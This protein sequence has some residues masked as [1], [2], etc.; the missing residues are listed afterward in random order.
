M[1]CA[2]DKR[3]RTQ[4]LVETVLFA[5]VRLVCSFLCSPS[6]SEFPFFMVKLVIL[7][8]GIRLCFIWIFVERMV[9]GLLSIEFFFEW[10]L[11]STSGL[12]HLWSQNSIISSAWSFLLQ[13]NS[14][15]LH[16]HRSHQFRGG[17]VST[18][19]NFT[20]KFW[21]FHDYD[22]NSS[23]IITNKWLRPIHLMKQYT[24]GVLS[25]SLSLT[26]DAS[27]SAMNSVFICFRFS[28][29]AIEEHLRLSLSQRAMWIQFS[30]NLV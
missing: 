12:I 18:D 19:F 22:D 13:E 14:F 16:P 11:Y 29:M 2:K 26:C 4:F 30:N 24:D 10:L 27:K 21:I 1:K 7:L 23:E 15:T 25:S 3:A 9:L 28:Q 8:F 5:R 17:I 6:P 20:S